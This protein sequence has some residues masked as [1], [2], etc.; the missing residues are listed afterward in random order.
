MLAVLGCSMLFTQGCVGRLVGEGAEKALGPKGAYFEDT[1]LAAKRGAKP[2]APYTQFE[3]APIKN[4]IGANLPGE[5]A[6]LF[7]DEFRKQLM[8]S[9]LP[10][11]AT[12]K[13]LLIETM[14]IHYE[15]A[16]TTDNVLG[17]L[18][19][20]VARVKLVDKATG[21]VLGVANC[22]G[23]TGK[24][25]GLGVDWKARGLAKGI[26]RWVSDNYSIKEEE[27]QKQPS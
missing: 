7:Y 2:L 16:D 9:K 12:G 3:L 17:P 19:Q 6:N 15:K 11:Q 21:K 10:K 22:I 1:P 23:R 20:V 26:L 13:T 24:S 18:E 25:V 5:F 14:I 4:D 8:E 27:A